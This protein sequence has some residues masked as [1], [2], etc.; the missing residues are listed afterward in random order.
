[1]VDERR[2][3][4]ENIAALKT[5]AILRI[6]EV[7]IASHRRQG[8]RGEPQKRPLSSATN[9]SLVSFNVH[10]ISTLTADI[11]FRIN[12]VFRTNQTPF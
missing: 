8:Q 7:A 2:K 4:V 6:C 12:S 11:G 3:E 10:Q 9:D 1:M 5:R